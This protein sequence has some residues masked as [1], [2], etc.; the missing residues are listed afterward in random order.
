MSVKEILLKYIE[1]DKFLDI[2]N[3]VEELYL[4]E[5][6]LLILM[7]RKFFNLFCVFHEINCQKYERRGI[8]YFNGKM[9][10]TN[11]ALPLLGADLKNNRFSKIIIADDI[12]IHGRSIREV[13]DEVLKLCPGAEAYLMSYMRNDEEKFIYEDI[14]TK[15]FSRYQAETSGEWRE[16]S[17]E[18]VKIFYMAGRPYISY[19]PYF[20]LNIEWERLKNKLKQGECLAIQDEDMGKYGVEAFMYIGKELEIFQKLAYCKIS[21]IRFYYYSELDNVMAVPYFCMDVMEEDSMK[22]LSDMARNSFFTQKYQRLAS[23]NDGADEM[24]IMELEYMLSA[25]LCMYVLDISGINAYT[26][27]KEIEQYNFC[28]M[29]L[30]E[31]SLSA[32]EIKH[33]IETVMNTDREICLQA[34]NLNSDIRV[35]LEEYDN[36]KKIYRN[37]FPRWRKMNSWSDK[38]GTYEQRF[39][40]NY[41]M[42]NGRID[43]ERCKGNSI[44]QKRLFGVPIGYLLDDIDDFLYELNEGQIDRGSCFVQ[45]F[46]AIIRALDSG[47][48]TVVTKVADENLEFRCIESVIYAGEQNYKFFENT[49]FPIMYGLYLIEKESGRQKNFG[50]I[51]ARKKE[52]VDCFA[53]YLEENCIFYI[54]EEMQQIALCDIGDSYEKFLQNSYEKYYNNPVLK[55]AVTMSLSICNR[56]DY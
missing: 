51:S 33:E 7:A 46:A 3:F 37:N 28:E 2:C 34:P 45:A 5:C 21:S 4:M 24:R 49:N 12:I 6:D 42:L 44:K 47:K 25:W 41:L 53:Q 23:Q 26:W 40:D 1:E 13:Y 30:P 56:A 11:R 48:G 15:M 29:L 17:D 18:F 32:R 22:E 54:K 35:L 50:K 39:I 9:I 27:H 43:E 52:M 19:L 10:V 16:M 55:A 38:M 8:P 36:L 20:S 31:K 14:M